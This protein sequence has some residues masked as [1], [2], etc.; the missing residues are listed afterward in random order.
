MATLVD[1][2]RS[3][4]LMHVVLIVPTEL[5][6]NVRTLVR[7]CLIGHYDIIKFLMV[8]SYECLHYKWLL[9]HSLLSQLFL[10]TFNA[11]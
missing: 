9:Y 11:S 1:I 6:C 10:S 4:A 7:T 8:V 3:L 5:M 2:I